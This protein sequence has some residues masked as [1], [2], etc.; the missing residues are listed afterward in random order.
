MPD[1][2]RDPH[3]GKMD[4]EQ[5]AWL[6]ARN[7]C[8]GELSLASELVSECRAR[9]TD[10]VAD[11]WDHIAELAAALRESGNVPGPTLHEILT[12]V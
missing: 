4:D 11:T 3:W 8:E 5:R 2:E 1:A 6:A 9:A 7:G 10:K 12:S